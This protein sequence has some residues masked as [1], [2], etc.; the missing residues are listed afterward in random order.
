MICKINQ[1]F[2]ELEEA[3]AFYGI[4]KGN[5]DWLLWCFLF[6][7]FNFDNARKEDKSETSESNMKPGEGDME[8]FLPGELIPEEENPIDWD[9][10]FLYYKH[11]F[12]IFFVSRIKSTM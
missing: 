7:G 4:L 10:F 6:L 5:L 3:Y 8:K 1:G 11:Y 12:M 9:I 2:D